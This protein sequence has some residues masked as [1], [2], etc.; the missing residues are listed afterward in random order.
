MT[1]EE[2]INTLV[3]TGKL[4]RT[5]VSIPNGEYITPVK[6]IIDSPRFIGGFYKKIAH[7]QI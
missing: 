3:V 6:D 1:N 2:F 4:K 7:C 5:I